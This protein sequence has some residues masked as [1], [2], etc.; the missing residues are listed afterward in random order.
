MLASR[1][2]SRKVCSSPAEKVDQILEEGLARQIG[3]VLL[4]NGA[5][6]DAHA[7]RDEF[8]AL[9]FEF[10]D[11]FADKASLARIGLRHDLCGRKR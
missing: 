5:L 9:V 3:V 7:H 6:R 2:I 10:R 1:M 4:D 11:D 8:E